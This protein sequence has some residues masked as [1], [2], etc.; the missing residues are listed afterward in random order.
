[1]TLCLRATTPFPHP[2][3][4]LARI[5]ETHELKHEHA[6]I[7][8][9]STEHGAGGARVAADALGPFSFSRFPSAGS[10]TATL[11]PSADF[12]HVKC[13][14]RLSAIRYQLRAAK[15]VLVI[16]LWLGL[17]SRN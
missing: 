7:L 15:T 10:D 11:V 2:A 16:Y 9:H 3:F 1:M 17:C 6:V 12:L 14:K 13:A 8:F 5:R 4:G